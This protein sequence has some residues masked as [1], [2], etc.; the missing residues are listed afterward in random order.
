MNNAF[1]PEDFV[2][3]LL[4]LDL[5]DQHASDE[6]SKARRQGNNAKQATM[7]NM[8]SRLIVVRSRLLAMQVQS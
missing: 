1:D 7:I 6:L 5:L 3:L 8:R 2:L 4:A